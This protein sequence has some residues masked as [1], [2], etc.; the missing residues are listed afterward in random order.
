MGVG[1]REARGDRL[2]MRRAVFV[3]RDGVLIRTPIRDGMPYAIS[4]EEAAEILPGVP[5]A[6]GALAKA[7]FL[8][9]MVTNQPDVARGRTARAFVEQTNRDLAARLQ[10]DAVRVCFHDD[11][12]NCS[13]RKPKPGLIVDAARDMGIDVSASFMVGDRWRDIAA[14]RRAGCSTILIDYGYAEPCPESPD[15]IAKSLLE[16][17]NWIRSV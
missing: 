10:L 8:L 13:C 3:D 7:G 9:V 2:S 1:R 14:G 12:D 15:H 5:E 4:A 17:S 16:A 11:D 6:C